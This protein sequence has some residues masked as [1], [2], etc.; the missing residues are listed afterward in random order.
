[1]CKNPIFNYLTK[2]TK[3]ICLFF[4]LFL[5]KRIIINVFISTTFNTHCHTGILHEFRRKSSIFFNILLLTCIFSTRSPLYFLFPAALI[6]LLMVD[7]P[8][9]VSISI[10]SLFT[11]SSPPYAHSLFPFFQLPHPH[12]PHSQYQLCS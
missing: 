10:L 3:K 11:N 1:M 7:F 6:L 2:K 8:Y 5:S 9:R 4:F 12:I